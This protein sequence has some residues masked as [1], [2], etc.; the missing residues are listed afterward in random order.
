[1]ISVATIYGLYV[2]RKVQMRLPAVVGVI[3]VFIIVASVASIEA[4][5]QERALRRTIQLVLIILSSLLIGIFLSIYINSRNMYYIFWSSMISS[6]ISIWT[7]IF[8]L[9]GYS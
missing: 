8:D 3:L 6:Q 1:M 4:I 2:A 7:I 9:V 5:E